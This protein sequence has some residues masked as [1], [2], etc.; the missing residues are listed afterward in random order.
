MEA[1][2]ITIRPFFGK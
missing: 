2:D 1:L